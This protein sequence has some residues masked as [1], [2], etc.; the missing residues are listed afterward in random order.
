MA[1]DCAK[2]GRTPEG[3]FN[4]TPCPQGLNLSPRGNVH[5]FVHPQ[6]W[7][8]STLGTE[9]WRGEQRISPPGDNSTPAPPQGTKFTPVGQL[10][11]WGQSLPLGA[12]LIMGLR[13]HSYD[14]EIQHHIQVAF[15]SLS[16]NFL[17]FVKTL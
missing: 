7:T 13:I 2:P 4:F 12:K 14:R 8:H 6:G 9:E 15:C 5:P 1:L 11:S 17:S 10:C 16:K 3:H